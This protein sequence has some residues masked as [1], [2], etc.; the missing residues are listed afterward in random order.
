MVGDKLF[1]IISEEAKE[2]KYKLSV[3]VSVI[4]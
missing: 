2:L 4:I 1:N 3:G